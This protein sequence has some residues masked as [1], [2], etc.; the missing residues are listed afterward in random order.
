LDRLPAIASLFG[1]ILFGLAAP[2]C[3]RSDRPTGDEVPGLRLEQVAFRV[4]RGSALRAS[5]QAA[6]VDYRRDADEVLAR[7]LTALLPRPGGPV[8]VK[9]ALGQGHVRGRA[10]QAEGGVEVVRAD[11]SARTDRA[12]YVG[13]PPEVIRGADPVHVAG[14]AWQLDGTGFTVDAETGD[15]VLGSG[16]GGTR[17]T[18]QVARFR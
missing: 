7:D 10:F 8:Q 14:A 17:L 2:G 16:G 5:G 1:T 9:A 13:G 11:V 3:Q 6:R 15:L 4:Y 18:A 12:E